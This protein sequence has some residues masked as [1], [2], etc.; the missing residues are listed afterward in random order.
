MSNRTQISEQVAA[1][2]A[3][4]DRLEALAAIMS[5]H[6]LTS[7]TVRHFDSLVN[8]S[9]GQALTTD[10]CVEITGLTPTGV[11]QL[12][13]RLAD[14]GLATRVKVY[15]STTVMWVLKKP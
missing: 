12:L 2:K 5:A 15:R 4:A 8:A 11:S 13:R 14:A 10:H 1:L 9:E 6:G 3:E 7:P